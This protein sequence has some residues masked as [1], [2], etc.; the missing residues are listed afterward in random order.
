MQKRRLTPRASVKR[1]RCSEVGAASRRNRSM[2]AKTTAGTTVLEPFQLLS[3]YRLLVGSSSLN[4]HTKLLPTGSF[5]A[6]TVNGALST[7]LSSGR[8][9]PLCEM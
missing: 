6:M 5:L 4:V 1:Q 7:R 2:L 8:I 3:S 9:A